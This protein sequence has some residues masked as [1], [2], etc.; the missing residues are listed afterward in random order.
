MAALIAGPA[1]ANPVEATSGV[2]ST[3]EITIT[4][5]RSDKG[6]VLLMLCPPAS[7][8]PDCR[9][10]VIRK[11][12]LAISGGVAHAHFSGIVPGKYAVS[13]FHD[14]NANGK[15]DTMMGIPR[16]G[17]GFSRNPPLRPRAP[18]F[19]ETDIMIEGNS[20]ANITIRY[21]L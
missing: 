7:G 6:S 19:D 11:A 17:F 9:G 8:F 18:R 2:L 13:A 3:L 10:K 15:M 5:L 16:E 21:I 4:G 14:A 1:R 20:T 12:T